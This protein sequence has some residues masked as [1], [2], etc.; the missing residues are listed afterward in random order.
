[1]GEREMSWKKYMAR[2]TIEISNQTFIQRIFSQAKTNNGL[3]VEPP[4]YRQVARRPDTWLAQRIA[5]LANKRRNE[6]R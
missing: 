5:Q 2:L 4:V 1:M 6:P 3:Y